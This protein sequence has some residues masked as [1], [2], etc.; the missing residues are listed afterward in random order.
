MM[1]ARTAE[2]YVS[3]GDYVLWANIVGFVRVA[4]AMQAMGVI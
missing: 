4:D 2:E 3:P 1:C